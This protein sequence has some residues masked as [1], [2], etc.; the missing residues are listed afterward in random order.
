[1]N[2]SSEQQEYPQHD[3]DQPKCGE[4]ASHEAPRSQGS[5]TL[6]KVTGPLEDSMSNRTSLEGIT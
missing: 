1:M 5:L 6:G 3:G 2:I 4:V